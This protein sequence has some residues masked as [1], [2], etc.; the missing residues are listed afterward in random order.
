MGRITQLPRPSRG[1]ESAGGSCFELLGSPVIGQELA[2]LADRDL[3]QFGK[4]TRL[5]CVW[6]T[7]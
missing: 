2:E 5:K 7:H 4:E 3:S 1:R 6:V